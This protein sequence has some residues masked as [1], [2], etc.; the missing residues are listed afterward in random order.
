MGVR[1]TTCLLMVI[2]YFDT[3]RAGR[4]VRPRE[5]NPPLVIDADAVLPLVGRPSAL[6]IGCPATRQG[7]SS[8]QQRPAGRAV[9]LPAGR[10]RRILE[11]LRHWQGVRFSCPDS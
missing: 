6:P 4:A 5:A 1:A 10:I 8:L 11:R 3:D 9:F 7:L 2:H